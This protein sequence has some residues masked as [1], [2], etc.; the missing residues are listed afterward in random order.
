MTVS[1][2]KLPVTPEEI[3]LVVGSLVPLVKDVPGR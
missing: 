1:T 3:L 2:N